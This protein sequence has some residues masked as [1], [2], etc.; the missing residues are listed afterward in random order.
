MTSEPTSSGQSPT[1]I[2]R[3]FTLGLSFGIFIVLLGGGISVFLAL[4]E[5][6]TSQAVDKENEHVVLLER[7]HAAFDHLNSEF[8]YMEAVGRHERM[9]EIRVLQS[10][11]MRHLESFEGIHQ[12]GWESDKDDRELSLFAKLKK[13]AGEIETLADKLAAPPSSAR[14]LPV[15]DL[16]R[17]HLISHEVP[18]TLE[19]LRD[20]HRIR[21]TRMLQASQ[22]TRQL[23][24]LFFLATI[25]LGGTLIVAARAAVR[26][27]IVAPLSTLAD[28]ALGIAEGRLDERIPV[29]STDE[30]GQVSRAFNSMAE[31]LQARQL[32]LRDAQE[33]LTQRVVKSHA[34][35]QIGTEIANLHQLD[36]ILQSVVEK[37]RE[38]LNSDATNLCL[39]GQENE[40]TCMARSGPPE[41]FATGTCPAPCTA[42]SSYDV[43]AQDSPCPLIR[44]EY[45]QEFL[46]GPLR[47]G[48]R[49]FGVIHA[50]RRN[51][52][53]FSPYDTELL[54]GLATQAAIAIENARLYQSGQSHAALQERE[55]LARE[56]HDGLAQTLGLL[57]LK[58]SRALD[59]MV[60][61]N[62]AR[63]TDALS[64]MK[65]ITHDTYDDVRQ[66]IFGLRTMV[67]HRLGLI[68][69]L[70]EFLH[71]FSD[72]NGVPVKFEVIDSQPIHLSPAS[73]VQL[74][75]IVQEALTNVRKH[76]GAERAWVRIQRQTPWI[77]V[78]IEDNGRGCAPATLTSLDRHHFG[79]QSMRERADG[80]GG[81]L[82][83]DTAP[84]RGMRVVATLPEEA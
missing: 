71:E 1:R 59:A 78:T 13:F 61:G 82:D 32:D 45:A 19:E 65:V 66:S 16:E 46:A 50:Y 57:H 49:A 47:R 80:L 70:T 42:V 8:Q 25:L 21:I 11:L 62:L 60:E 31:R 5:S 73:E 43:E 20:I 56:M 75:R 35:F 36:R 17:L 74:I 9:R 77:Q 10:D 14:R 39:Y 33:Q 7:I 52:P 38:L 58:L 18:N 84:G 51:G 48:E 2:A 12:R 67:S 55:R 40:I 79:L 34:L 81:K 37:T 27:R 54:F 15:S 63:I 41:A 30:I 83:I 72:Q 68:P 69:S 4:Q 29:R 22:G 64:E 53:K 23:I 24:V 26:Q 3:Q 28:T 6:R 76:S 44:P